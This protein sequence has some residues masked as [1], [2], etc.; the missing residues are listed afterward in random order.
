MILSNPLLITGFPTKAPQSKE[1]ELHNEKRSL[2]F[3]DF[4]TISFCFV[5]SP[6]SNYYFVYQESFQFLQRVVNSR[7]LE[8]RSLILAVIVPM[9]NMIL[10]KCSIVVRKTNQF[11]CD[12]DGQVYCKIFTFMY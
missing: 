1:S 9:A 11:Y 2:A 6:L 7:R 4:F 5:Q 8:G 10:Y 3:Y 12:P